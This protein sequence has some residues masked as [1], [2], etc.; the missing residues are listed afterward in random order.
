MIINVLGDSITEGALASSEDKTFVSTLARL[1]NC[2]VNNYGISGSRIAKQLVPSA[3]PR[4][5][6]FFGSRVKDLVPADLVIVFGGTNDYGHGDASIGNIEDK[7]P[8]TF[9]GG[10]NYLISELLKK[11][12]K[13]QILF[14]LPLYRIN[15]DDPLGDHLRKEATLSLQG[16]RDIMSEVLQSNNINYLDIKD[17]LGRPGENDHFGD[18]LHPNDKGHR[19]IAELLAKYIKAHY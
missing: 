5:D 6:L 8:D 3:E 19:L 7:T 13:E 9:Y 1:L 17:N 14:I 16:Y 12:R 15:E 10:M 2:K 18:G 4:F 11:Y